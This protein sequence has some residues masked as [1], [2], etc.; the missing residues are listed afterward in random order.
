MRGDGFGGGLL[1]RLIG[2][3]PTRWIGELRRGPT[4]QQRRLHQ[5][6]GALTERCSCR[7]DIGDQ[8][9]IGQPVAVDHAQRPLPR[10]A[11]QIGDV[12]KAE[13]YDGLTPVTMTL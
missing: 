9:G 4:P 7:S 12:V 10:L 11:T 8:R 2:E 3:E 6:G 5:R 13:I 1:E